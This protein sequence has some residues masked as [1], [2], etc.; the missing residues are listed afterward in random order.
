MGM[1][2][3][4]RYLLVKTGEP[5]RRGKRYLLL[6]NYDEEPVFVNHARIAPGDYFVMEEKEVYDMLQHIMYEKRV[7]IMKSIQPES[8]SVPLGKDEMNEDYRTTFV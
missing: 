2:L 7:V 5:Y 4:Y 8:D 3:V 6:K 1:N